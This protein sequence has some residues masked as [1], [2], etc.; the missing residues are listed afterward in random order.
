MLGFVA[1]DAGIAQPLLRR[2]VVRGGRRPFN[3]ISVNGDTS[4]ND[5]FLIASGASG[6]AF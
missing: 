5:S 3:C 4:T 1:T 6:A 2:P